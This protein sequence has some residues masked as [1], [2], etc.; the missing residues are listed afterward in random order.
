MKARKVVK[1]HLFNQSEK[2][3]EMLDVILKQI[4]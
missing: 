3:S 2:D 4:K 1:M